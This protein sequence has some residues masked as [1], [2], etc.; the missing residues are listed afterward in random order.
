MDSNPL[1][2]KKIL[3]TAGP[4]WVPIDDVR[5]ISNISSGEMGILLAREAAARGLKVDLLLGPVGAVSLG[6]KIR[7]QRFRYFQELLDLIKKRP[8]VNKYDIILHAAAVSDYFCKPV[9]GKISSK[10]S[11]HFLKLKITPKI[12]GVMRRLNPE[13]YLVMFK[14]EG[15][16][17]DA[18]L[19]KR[20]L[21][22]MKKAGA[23][24]VVANRF[25]NGR[26]RGFILGA[27]ELL[28]RTVTKKAMSLSLFRVLTTRAER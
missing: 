1:R 4:T 12:I 14:L 28:A 25:V 5:V 19:L 11:A 13:A 24:L 26:Y 6:K 23:D 18:V 7:V 10:K 3:I 15:R 22:G 16:V 9:A 8:K 17:S 27:R 21:E 2:G 20:A